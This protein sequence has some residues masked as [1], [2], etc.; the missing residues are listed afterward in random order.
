MELGRLR[1]RVLRADNRRLHLLRVTLPAV[2]EG[3]TEV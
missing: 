2:Q 3:E 1:L